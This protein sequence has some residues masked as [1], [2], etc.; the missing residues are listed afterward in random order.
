MRAPV[1]GSTSKKA[2]LG[3]AVF[4][5][6]TIV[7]GAESISKFSKAGLAFDVEA[8]PFG[9]EFK[10]DSGFAN[11]PEPKIFY[12]SDYEG[13]SWHTNQTSV[14]YEKNFPNRKLAYG[15][16]DRRLVAVR[17]HINEINPA[18]PAKHPAIDKIRDSLSKLTSEG[19]LNFEDARHHIEYHSFC[20]PDSN[21]VA[22]IV[23][24]PRKKQ[25]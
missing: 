13:V 9:M 3:L 4:L 14:A 23:I 15:F 1:S 19:K 2:W 21:C 7:Q 12:W 20:R 17:I 25:P 11:V 8:C 16:R 5:L 6:T 24:T 22:T 10:A 18:N